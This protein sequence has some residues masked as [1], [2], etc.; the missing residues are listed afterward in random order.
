MPWTIS[1]GRLNVDGTIA[2]STMTVN[3]GGTLGGSGT[4]GSTAITGGT[5]APG[6]AVGSVF[7]PLAVQGNL[8]FTAASTY[9][10]QVSPANAGRTNVLGTATLGGATV[11]ASFAAGTFVAKQYTILHATGGVTG[12]FGSQVNTNLPAG[13]KSSLSYDGNDAYLNLALSFIPPSSPN[14]GGGLNGNQTRV[15]T[16]LVNFFNSAGGIPMVFGSLSP[17]GL[18]QASGE[19][20]TGTQQ[21]TFNAMNQFMG[22]MTDPF[23]AGRGEGGSVTG[24]TTAM[25]T[26]RRSAMRERASR[27]MRWR[28]STPRRH[29]LS[30]SRQA[31][32]CGRRALAV[33]RPPTAIRRSDR[34][35]LRAAFTARRSA[36]TTASR[37]IRWRALRLPAAAPISASTGRA[38]GAPTCSRPAPSCGTMWV[39][40]TSLRHWLTAGRTSPPIAPSPLPV[41][42]TCARNSTPTPIRA[43]SRAATVSSRRGWASRLTRPASSPRSTCR[44]MQ[45]ARS[46]G[47]NTFALAYGAKSVTDP[48]SE[49]GLRSDK[50]FALPD[51]ILTLRGRAA[52]AHDYDPSR[53][54]GATFQTLPGASFVVDGAAQASDSALVTASAEMKWMNGWSAAAT[55]E[56]EFSDVTESYAG[57]GVVRYAW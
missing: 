21:T 7:G 42:I 16:A 52:W 54:I 1:A 26:R 29:S 17:A 48:R 55:F 2:N 28:R 15:G 13:F 32:A 50:S 10:I 8:S 38:V 37:R 24:G 40:P 53:A 19:T 18:T 20:A 34:T 6:S 27:T 47:A 9:M 3:A 46:S 23:V 49:L 30:R 35:T 57:K 43:G 39:W 11:N 25:P 45:S 41:P 33:R 31:G 4:V 12:T 22:V 5:L 36:P 14:F 51:A 44:P 56:G